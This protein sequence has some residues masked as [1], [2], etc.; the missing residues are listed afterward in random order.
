[1]RCC[2]CG[3][4]AEGGHENLCFCGALPPGF[5][6]RLRCIENDQRSTENQAEI[7]AAEVA[8]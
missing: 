6:A 7:V 8:P 5:K 1:V 3:A 2:D 4:S